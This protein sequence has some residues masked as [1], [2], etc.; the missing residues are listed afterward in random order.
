MCWV[1]A[2][3]LRALLRV[4]DI[5]SSC[6]CVIRK[7][8]RVSNSSPKQF[9]CDKQNM[10]CFLL[11]LVKQMLGCVQVFSNQ[12][13]YLEVLKT[14]KYLFHAILNHAVY[15]FMHIYTKL[16]HV[17]YI[18]VTLLYI[19]ISRFVKPLETFDIYNITGFQNR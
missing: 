8:A 17:T 16:N 13:A 1:L 3:R 6:C 5:M 9:I 19:K 14:P 4:R 18:K 10:A 15:I 11:K 2:T 7:I 12:S